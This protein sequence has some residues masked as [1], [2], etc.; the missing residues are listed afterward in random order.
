[1]VAGPGA[2]KTT[3]AYEVCAALKKLGYGVEYAPEYA[4]EL[5]A[6]GKGRLLAEGSLETQRK[7]FVEQQRRIDRWVGKVDFVVTDSAPILGLQYLR[8]EGPAAD[9]FAEEVKAAFAKTENFVLFVE[10]GPYYVQEGRVQTEEQARAVDA[11]VKRYLER[12]GVFYGSY[13]H[14]GIETAVRNMQSTLSRLTG[15]HPD[16]LRARGAVRE[17]CAGVLMRAYADAARTAPATQRA[18]IETEGR[19]QL[20]RFKAAFDAGEPASKV[21]SRAYKAAG[22]P[23]PRTVPEAYKPAVAARSGTKEGR[24]TSA[25]RT[26][27]RKGAHPPSSACPRAASTPAEERARFRSTPAVGTAA[28]PRTQDGG[29][30]GR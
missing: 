22:V 29:A 26:E 19:A 13:G 28:R 25:G 1:M 3:A 16:D 9:A 21:R 30:R 17:E 14:E 27:G 6:D 10:R 8:E 20:A 7:L 4:K 11:A 5:L 15:K 12:S 24:A 23:K 18:R 2:G